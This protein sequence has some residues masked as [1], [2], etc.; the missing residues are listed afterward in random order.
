MYEKKHGRLVN[1][2]KENKVKIDAGEM[3]FVR[4]TQGLTMCSDCEK[5]V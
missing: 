1:K 4:S 5:G 3:R 2:N